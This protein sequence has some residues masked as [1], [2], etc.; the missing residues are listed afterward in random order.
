MVIK[1]AGRGIRA[2]FLWL[3]DVWYND[4]LRPYNTQG[5]GLNTG[6]LCWFVAF[7]HLI[8]HT[9]YVPDKYNSDR[10]GEKENS[11]LKARNKFPLQF[12]NVNNLSNY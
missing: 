12:Y 11:F 5:C 1:G 2:K 6:A 9:R 7:P 3:N 4:M 10:M 8:N